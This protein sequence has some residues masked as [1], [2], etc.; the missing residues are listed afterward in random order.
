MGNNGLGGGGG[1]KTN[2]GRRGDR[3]LY[4]YT[5]KKGYSDIP[6][7]EDRK[8]GNLFLQCILFEPL[9][10]MTKSRSS[11]LRGLA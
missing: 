7:G 2:R 4:P 6:D 9:T 8:I 11:S 10:Q 5:V 3:C 1:D